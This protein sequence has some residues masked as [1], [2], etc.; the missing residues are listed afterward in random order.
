MKNPNGMPA[1][2][3]GAG[4]CGAAGGGVARSVS[5]T[6]VSGE[7]AG[8]ESE[9]VPTGAS[10]GVSVSTIGSR[11]PAPHP[12]ATN[13]TAASATAR[14]SKRQLLNLRPLGM[15]VSSL[16]KNQGDQSFGG[17]RGPAPGK[18]TAAAL[19]NCPS[20][21]GPRLLP[22]SQPVKRLRTVEQAGLP[23]GSGLGDCITTNYR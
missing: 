12:P 7:P 18:A 22:G 23:P 9:A 21:R 5:G 2:V 13:T 15:R 3:L 14:Q 8:V 16:L 10:D 11:P 19:F 6:A 17:A 20:R 4:V 1:W